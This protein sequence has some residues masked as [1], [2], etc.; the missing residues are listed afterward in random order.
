MPSALSIPSLTRTIQTPVAYTNEQVHHYSM[1][2]QSWHPY[3]KVVNRQI[4]THCSYALKED[5]PSL[6][7]A[8]QLSTIVNSPNNSKV[9][10]DNWTWWNDSQWNVF[11][12]FLLWYQR[13]QYNLHGF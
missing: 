7:K 11:C 12:L 3:T 10:C 1:V 2:W 4:N 13:A 6:L 5:I 8:P 9:Y